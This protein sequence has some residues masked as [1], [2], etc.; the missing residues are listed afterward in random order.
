[1]NGSQFVAV[2]D[3]PELLKARQDAHR[4]GQMVQVLRSYGLTDGQITH[5]LGALLREG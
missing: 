3:S 5:L 2:V 1:M 4:I